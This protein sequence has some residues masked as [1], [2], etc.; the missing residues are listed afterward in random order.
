[1]FS[2]ENKTMKTREI[3]FIV[4]CTATTMTAIVSISMAHGEATAGELTYTAIVPMHH[5]WRISSENT[6]GGI[7][8]CKKEFYYEH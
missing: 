6:V 3:I 8:I 2:T 5:V 1:M 4:K 7:M